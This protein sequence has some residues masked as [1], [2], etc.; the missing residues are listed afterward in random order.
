V[1]ILVPASEGKQTITHGKPVDLARLSFPALNPTRA[2][3]PDALV[4]ASAAPE[5]SSEVRARWGP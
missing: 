4:D 1:L 5:R 3:V 2:A